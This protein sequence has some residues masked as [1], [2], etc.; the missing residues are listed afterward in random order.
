MILNIH[1]LTR[2]NLGDQM[3]GPGHYFQRMAGERVC[4]WDIG[5]P[6]P[7][8]QVRGAIVGGGG[9]FHS[10]FWQR[11]MNGLLGLKI[12]V[13]A[14]GVGLNHHGKLDD[15]FPA[16]L[17]RYNLV[18]VRDVV[19]GWRWVPCVSCLSTAFDVPRRSP[20]HELVALEH[21]EVPLKV[22]GIPKATMRCASMPEILSHIESGGTVITNTYHGVYWSTLMGKP[23]VVVNPFSSRFTRFRHPPMIADETNWRA[24]AH[25]ARA[26]PEALAECREANAR[27]AREVEGL[28][29]SRLQRSR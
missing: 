12:P 1:A 8:H 11:K 27:F 19:D 20:A 29:C 10:F 2:Y 22:D 6:I 17:K 5:T 28:L 18:G 24:K 14:W 26:Y 21:C 16:W 23:V 3:A 4:E 25:E 15:E 13:V 9:L 7:T